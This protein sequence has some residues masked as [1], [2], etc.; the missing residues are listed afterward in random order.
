MK[1]I[2]SLLIWCLLLSNSAFAAIVV[3]PVLPQ[4][5]VRDIYVTN[6]VYSDASFTVTGASLPDV[7]GTYY[8]LWTN[9]SGGLW[10]GVWTNSSAGGY[11]MYLNDV[12]GGTGV[13]WV[14]ETSTNDVAPPYGGATDTAKGPTIPLSPFEEISGPAE[15]LTIGVSSVLV[16]VP[17]QIVTVTNAIWAPYPTTNIFV[18]NVIGDDTY[19]NRSNGVPFATIPVALL[20]ARSNDVVRCE[21]GFYR[22]DTRGY[23]SNG[24]TLVAY[25]CTI[26]T[27]LTVL[28]G[29]TLLGGNHSISIL[30]NATNSLLNTITRDVKVEGLADGIQIDNANGLMQ[31]WNCDFGSQW[32][33]CIIN[34]SSTNSI[35]SF[36]NTRLWCINRNSPQAVPWGFHS[37]GWNMGTTEGGKLSLNN[38]LIENIGSTNV[39]FT[40]PTDP[41]NANAGI[42]INPDTLGVTTHGMASL[43]LNNVTI[44]SGSTNA[45]VVVN[46]ISNVLNIPITGFYQDVKA[47]ADRTKTN[48]SSTFVSFGSSVDPVI[49][50]TADYTANDNDSL[51]RINGTTKTVTLPSSIGR[52]GKTFTIKLVANSTGTVGTTSSQTIDASTTYSLSAQ[53]KYVTVKSDGANWSIV[54]NN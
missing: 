5:K 24:V 31:W 37:I 6:S 3:G 15:L 40:N 8:K 29:A 41:S 25:G 10:H 38:V 26:A 35:M 34:A 19:A 27:P 21:P 45:G 28:G 1:L 9:F 52:A 42:I 2:F 46:A 32:D 48:V 44:V 22:S 49:T 18:N 7:D 23:I 4:I 47:G 43:E 14:I 50:V 39:T 12:A 16:G 17:E 54:A 11:F 30:Y 53:Y 33:A 51:I 36:H 20:A 13:A